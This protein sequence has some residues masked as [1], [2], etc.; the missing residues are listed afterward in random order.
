M[1]DSI[2]GFA[3]VPDE[4]PALL[5]CAPGMVDVLASGPNYVAYSVF[6]CEEDTNPAAMVAVAEVSGV[7]FDLGND[8]AILCGAVLVV[9]CD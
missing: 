1:P 4:V 7:D 2:T 5:G 9:R 6:D 3:R 8:D